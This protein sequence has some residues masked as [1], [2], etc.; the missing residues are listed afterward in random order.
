M[1][2]DHEIPTGSALQR[3]LRY[4]EPSADEKIAERP[5][6][7]T[8]KQDGPAKSVDVGHG[9]SADPLVAVKA[10]VHKRLLAEIDP[11]QASTDDPS[12]VRAGIRR[13][14]GQML[15]QETGL[16]LEGSQLDVLADEVVDDVLGLGPI[17][18]L[19]SDPTVTEV[20]VNGPNKIY[21]ERAGKLYRSDRAFRNQA[22]VR[23]V[24]ERILAPLGR[25]ID[26]QSAMADARLADGSRV[27]IVIPPLSVDGPVITIRKFS[28]DVIT[29]E[30]L[31]ELGALTPQIERFLRGC[32]AAKL[33]TV[34]S[35]GTG[36]GKTTFLNVLSTFIGDDERIITIEDPAE[37]QL[38]QN[39]VIRLETRP[40][41]VLGKSEV[42]QRELVRNALR[43]RPDRIVVGGVRGGEAFDMLQAMNTGHEGSLTTVHAN[44][45]RDALA[46][47]QNMVLMAGLD[48]PERA[49]KEQAVSAIDLIVQLSR[50]S[51][52]SRRLTHVTE[53]TGMEGDIVTAQDI[54]LFDRRGVDSDGRVLGSIRPTGLVPNFLDR[55]ERAGFPMEPEIFLA[56]DG[57]LP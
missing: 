51:D 8:G 36:S 41:N 16:I 42:R 50:F 46:R 52:G 18:P 39:N 14:A 44:T 24:A 28:R 34:I 27:N 3:L 49:I 9:S 35:G 48:L 37:L 23:Q 11:T 10:R 6:Q 17:E 57:I 13:L 1:A 12:I 5:A 53:I 29:A 25:R 21:F 19:L 56:D 54:F 20:M 31:I 30:R 40:P 15:D 32:V 43:M 26:E 7:N 22:H 55:L 45:P 33:N 4:A 38:A 2:R 47:I